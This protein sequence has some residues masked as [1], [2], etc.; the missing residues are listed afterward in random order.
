MP[1]QLKRAAAAAI[2]ALLPATSFADYHVDILP[3]ASSV[4][5]Q[6]YDL[7]FGIL[8]VCV[9]IFI[10][11]FGA[12]FWSVFAHR[13]SRGAQA[14]QFHENTTIEIIWTVIPFVILIGMAYPATRTV[15]D[16]KDASNPDMSIK[17]TAYQWKWQYDYLQDGVSFY[18]NLSTPRDQIEEFGGQKGAKKNANYLLEVDNPVVVPVGKKIR[19]L[20][21]ANDVI[22][23]WY[24]PQLGINQYG[25]PGFVKDAWFKADKPGR[26][27]GQCSQICGKEHGYMPIVVDV[28]SEADY[29]KWVKEMKAKMPPPPAPVQTAAA[30][31]AAAEDL[32]KKWTADELK[33]AG[34]K[35]YAAN[36]V[37]CHQAT[38]KGM[39]P[40]FPA[41]DGSKVVQGPKAAQVA[42]VLKGRPNTAMASFAHLSNTDLAAVIT[43]T[44]TSWGNK[45]GE[46]Q[47]AEVK[48]AR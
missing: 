15:L 33:A 20:I 13:K 18:A 4:A 21:T 16:M 23:G 46:V 22:H 19:L 7:H 40:A 24:V 8:W 37:A 39:P 35:V 26:Y 45:S 42:T 28:V 17:V 2:A 29:A 27:L 9:A 10:I 3:P 1:V 36:C 30:A 34:E 6:I 47:P 48:A 38:G 44:R 12:M 41:L 11:V 31:P 43:Y 32:T 14:A 5:Q 25:I